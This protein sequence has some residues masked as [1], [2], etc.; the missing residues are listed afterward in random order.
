MTA[1][2]KRYVW[3]I[4]RSFLSKSWR[5]NTKKKH[6]N[7]SQRENFVQF[8]QQ[9]PL[10]EL[11][12]SNW[13]NVS[14]YPRNCDF[15]SVFRFGVFNRDF[16]KGNKIYNFNLKV[17]LFM[18]PFPRFSVSLILTISLSLSLPLPHIHFSVISNTLIHM[19][20]IFLVYPLWIYIRWRDVLIS[21]HCCAFSAL[22]RASFSEK[23]T[24]KL[25]FSRS[26]CCCEYFFPH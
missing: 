26:Q 18:W 6:K 25:L 14:N 8:S 13:W 9:T 2:D 3:C 24:N 17:Y 5:T 15:V 19:Q 11:L 22:R 23:K 7:P 4:A 12:S 16:K 20:H 10:T 21:H 1:N